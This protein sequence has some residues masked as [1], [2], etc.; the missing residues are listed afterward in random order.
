MATRTFFRDCQ[1]WEW[2]DRRFD[3]V[4]ALAVPRSVSALI[5]T[6]PR[7]IA[8]DVWAKLLWAGLNLD[9]SDLPGNSADTYYPME[10]IRAITLTGL[11][12]GLRSDELSRLRVGCVRWQYDGQPIAADSP[13]VLAEDAVC[14]LEVPAHKTGTAFTKPVDPL[15]GQS[16]EAWQALRPPQPTTLDRN[17][18]EQVDMLFAVRAHPVAKKLHQPHDHPCALRQGRCPRAATS[19]AT[20]P[21]T[22]PAPRPR[23]S[24]TT[25]RNR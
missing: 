23:P 4:R 6:N 22:G 11:F 13:D 2:I 17:T 14:L 8:D 18:S 15:Q 25:P 12:G 21:V 9:S 16:I 19:A 1:E 20:S 3:P 5:G 7:V 10:L 24:S